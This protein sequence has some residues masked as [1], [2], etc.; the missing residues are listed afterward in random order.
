MRKRQKITAPQPVIVTTNCRKCG[1]PWVAHGQVPTADD[2]IRVLRD[3][4]DELEMDI[5]RVK[6]SARLSAAR[7]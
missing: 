1:G 3:R 5:H 6:Q 2:C 7:K 4:C